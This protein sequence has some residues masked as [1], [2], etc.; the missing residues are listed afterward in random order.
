MYMKKLGIV[1]WRG[2]VGSV[3][4][5]RMSE[6]NDFVNFKTHFF[7]TSQ[8][9]QDAPSK[10]NAEA[11]LLDAYRLE[12]LSRMDIIVTAQGSDYTKT[13]HANLR[14]LGW[15]G[16]WIDAASALRYEPG[17]TLLLDPV[18]R[19]LIDAAIDSGKKD[20]IG[21]NCTVG[22]MLMGIGGLF[23]LDLVEWVSN[24]TY[25]A[26]SGAGARGVTEMLLQMNQIGL[27]AKEAIDNPSKSILDIDRSVSELLKGSELPQAQFGAPLAGSILP[28]VDTAVDDG[29]S[30]EEWKGMVETNKIL[31]GKTAVPID[32]TC[33]RVS[34]MRCHSHGLTIKLK[35]DLPLSEIESIIESSTEWTELVDNNQQDSLK[36]LNPASVS[37]NLAVRVGRV[38]KMKLG[39][40]YLN[41]FV[42][43]DQLLWGA[44]EP[45]RR[46]LNILK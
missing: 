38:R 11:K 36:K 13:V 37:G 40:K 19:E 17:S 20:F 16:Y 23:T 25:Q 9:G 32:G 33:V 6:E 1:G 30:R 8:A 18:N 15:S 12:E 21:A 7:S 26:A 45:L 22:T 3:L 35:Q 10:A 14:Q 44:A 46:M 42:V 2:M 27:V 39:P 29:Q 31:G 4:I 43:G 28:W 41:A 24:M 34:S 5:Q